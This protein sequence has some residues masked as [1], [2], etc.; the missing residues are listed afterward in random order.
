MKNSYH[1][2]FPFLNSTHASTEHTEGDGAICN[3]N[4][5]NMARKILNVTSKNFV[6][7]ISFS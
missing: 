1:K 7:K 6:Y 3:T 4:G 2:F 5:Q